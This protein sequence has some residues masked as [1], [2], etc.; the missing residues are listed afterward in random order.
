MHIIGPEMFMSVELDPHQRL[1][2][3]QRERDTLKRAADIYL[4]ADEMLLAAGVHPDD[5][6]TRGI[7]IDGW[8]RSRTLAEEGIIRF[9]PMEPCALEDDPQA[10]YFINQHAHLPSVND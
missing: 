2:L 5:Y 3:T 1:I 10:D 4:Q 8:D 7:L 6:D 9:L